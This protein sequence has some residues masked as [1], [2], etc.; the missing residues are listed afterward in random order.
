MN[1]KNILLVTLTVIIF[2]VIIGI[3]TYAYFATGLLNVSNVANLNA[4]T[5]RNNM[6]FDT[7]GGEMTLNV[8]A[9]N[10]AESLSGNIAAENNTTLTVSFTPNTEYSMICTYDIVYEWTSSDRYTTHSP[11]ETDIE[12]GIYVAL[13]SGINVLGGINYAEDGVDL[14][15][16]V[17][18]QNSTTV[19]SGATIA[20]LGANTITAEWYIESWFYNAYTDQSALSGKTYTGRFKVANVSCTAGSASPHLTS[21]WFPTTLAT[22]NSGTG[23][24]EPNYTHPNYGGTVQ[25]TGTATG[26]NIYIGQDSSKYYAC[27]ND[28]YGHEVCLSQPYTQYGL[29]GH[30]EGSE[31]T[32]EQETSA[33][34][35]LY[36]AFIAAG[37]P[38]DFYNDCAAGDYDAYCSVADFKCGVNISGH[39]NCSNHSENIGCT[40]EQDGGAYC[41]YNGF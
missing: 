36:Q 27:G 19:V 3:A 41:Y 14:S 10:M 1:R 39:V 31:L 5:E 34:Q 25:N 2:V 12:L 29:S 8:T 16:L 6:V 7:L 17:G 37:L 30:T 15:E 21:Y 35:A 26:H 22:Y 18:N 32:R 4:V 13:N 20:G 9:A 38:V 24:Y 23:Q 11:G 33:K 40:V 28:G